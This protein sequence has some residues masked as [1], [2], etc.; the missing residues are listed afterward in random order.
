MVKWAP[1]FVA[2]RDLGL[3]ALFFTMSGRVPL[4]IQYSP[5]L[6]GCKSWSR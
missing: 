5:H 6:L 3:C 2:S 1:L 4:P